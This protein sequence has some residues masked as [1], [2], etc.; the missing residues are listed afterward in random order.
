LCFQLA[1][2]K[3]VTA[4]D[5]LIDLAPIANVSQRIGVKNHEVGEFAGLEPM[6]KPLKL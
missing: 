2:L 1:D 3:D 6:P 4:F 5:N